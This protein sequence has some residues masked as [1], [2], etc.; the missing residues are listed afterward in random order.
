MAMKFGKY[1][2]KMIF[3]T[4]MCEAY[5]DGDYGLLH[6]LCDLKPWEMSPTRCHLWTPARG[7]TPQDFR[8]RPW[9]AS[10]WKIMAIR[11]QLEAM[12]KRE[13]IKPSRAALVRQERKRQAEIAEREAEKSYVNAIA[14]DHEP[15]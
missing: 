6:Q 12:A 1:L 11:E 3:E 7:E 8:G 4:A 15:D 5:V 9:F 2:P 14:T 10:W 13:G